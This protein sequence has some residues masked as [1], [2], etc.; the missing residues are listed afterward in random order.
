MG[1]AIVLTAALSMTELLR[2]RIAEGWVP[3]NIEIYD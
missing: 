3:D 1:N 2:Q